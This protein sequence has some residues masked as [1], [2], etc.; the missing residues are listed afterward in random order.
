MPPLA[1]KHLERRASDLAAFERIY[2]MNTKSAL[3][4]EAAHGKWRQAGN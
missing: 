3:S 4:S 2:F 1:L